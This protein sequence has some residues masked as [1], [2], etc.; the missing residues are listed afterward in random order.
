MM[1]I[2]VL[3]ADKFRARF[4]TAQTASSPLDEVRD[5]VHPEAK[6]RE[7]DLVTD[8]GGRAQAPMR[9]G[10]QGLGKEAGRKDDEA[11][12]FALRVCDELESAHRKGEFRKLYVIAAP[13]FL[14]LLRRHE[15]NVLR[16]ALALEMPKNLAQQDSGAI[17]RHL[18][19]F[20]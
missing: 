13:A 5:L 14:G 6:L 19:R 4:F 12:R 20:L 16:G 2:L 10:V 18:P 3:V 17:R 7:G 1:T 15:S 9:G 11:D 8:R